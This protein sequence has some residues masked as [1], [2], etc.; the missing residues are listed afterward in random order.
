MKVEAYTIVFLFGA[1]LAAFFMVVLVGKKR[2]ESLSNRLLLA[3][4]ASIFLV[5]VQYS[6]TMNGLADHFPWIWHMGAAVWYTISPLL[7]LFTMSALKPEFRMRP[8]HGWLFVAAFYLLL[9]FVLESSGIFV[10]FH[11]LFDNF[12]A[13]SYAWLLT[14]HIYALGMSVACLW[15]IGKAGK[16]KD[17]SARSAWLRIFFWIMTGL[18]VVSM[19]MLSMVVNSE[20][21]VADYEWIWMV[22]FELFVFGIFFIA[23]RSS[24]LLQ[25]GTLKPE[26]PDTE[27]APKYVNATKDTEE[28]AR[29]LNSLRETMEAQQPYLDGKLSLA[30]LANLSGISQ[31]DLSQLFSQHL[32]SNF[33]DFVNDYRLRELEKRLPDPAYRHFKIAALAE[34]CGFNSKASFYRYFK[35]RH[36]MTPTEF[37]KLQ[38]E[39]EN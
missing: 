1:L 37:L 16:K 30:D 6:I 5:L 28:M 15:M 26:S 32:D 25:P 9:Q 27:S 39:R 24:T 35:S 21:Y 20:V 8:V 13:Y 17:L 12:P 19:V 10:G 18:I 2:M 33:Y 14:Y 31:N 7:L 4:M 23:L 29:L 22:M 34:D 11:M 3:L 36:Q 38:Q